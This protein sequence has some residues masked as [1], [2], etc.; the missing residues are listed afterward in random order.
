LGSV[1]LT[2][3]GCVKQMED[4]NTP[5]TEPVGSL[6]F[7][8]YE[9]KFLS[10]IR[11]TTKSDLYSLGVTVAEIL[12]GSHIVEE[13][14]AV[15]DTTTGPVTRSED[16]P[17]Q[18]PYKIPQSVRDRF[19]SKSA[20]IDFLEKCLEKNFTKRPSAEMLLQHSFLQK[21]P[22]M[23]LFGDLRTEHIDDLNSMTEMLIE[24]YLNY[25]KSRRPSASTKGVN[26]EELFEDL[27]RTPIDDEFTDSERIDN[28]ARFS[29]FSVE[30]VQE[31]IYQ[32]V[33]DVKNQYLRR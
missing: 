31:Y 9:K 27:S 8:S 28:I 4:A 13:E 6:R 16:D 11:Y 29:G 21:S 22:S 20:V 24:Y 2:D 5:L 33:N 17:E 15:T 7:Q 1:K 32:S 26:G 10:P 19:Q 25:N 30:R 14:V 23:P 12:N 3:F 18:I